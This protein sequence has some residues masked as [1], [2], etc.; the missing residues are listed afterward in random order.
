MQGLTK[1]IAIYLEIRQASG[2]QRKPQT[3][4]F[5]QPSK[6]EIIND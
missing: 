5:Q 2:L 3:G 6:E 1:K 4:L